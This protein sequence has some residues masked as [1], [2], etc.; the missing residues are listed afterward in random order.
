VSSDTSFVAVVFPSAEAAQDALPAVHALDSGK[1]VSVRDAAVVVRTATGRIE[2][3]Q[4][5]EVAPG[6]AIVGVGGAGLV[7][8]LLLGVPVGGALL[9]LA[10]GALWGL[11][12]T[13][14]PDRRLRKL[15]ED[16]QPGQAMLCVLIDADGISPTREALGVYGTVL[17]VELSSDPGP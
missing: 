11:R 13:G 15:G 7:A 3:V 5:R 12:D 9:G 2:L 8:G 10:G 16:L 14:I 1:E 4:T 6:E 17:E